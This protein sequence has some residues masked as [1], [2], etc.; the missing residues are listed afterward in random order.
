MNH[1]PLKLQYSKMTAGLSDIQK[2]AL[3]ERLFIAPLAETI[4]LDT[5]EGRQKLESF[6]IQY[7]P[8][9]LFIDSL[10]ETSYRTLL[11]DDG[12]RELNRF[13]RYIRKS[14]YVQFTSSIMTG[15]PERL[16]TRTWTLCGGRDLYLPP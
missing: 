14:M 1:P 7:R 16:V 3:K 8:N 6:L 13:L 4:P 2:Q 9:V 5:P 15:N 12:V 11:E 10:S